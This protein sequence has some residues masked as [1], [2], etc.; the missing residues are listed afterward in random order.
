MTQDYTIEE[1][2][3]FFA[4]A[5]LPEG[6]VSTNSYSTTHDLKQFIAAQFTL[7]E[8]TSHMKW[9]TPAFLRLVEVKGWL[10]KG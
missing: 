9:P 8:N 1:L 7:I 5:T 2:R 4:T 10:E 6:P 3:S